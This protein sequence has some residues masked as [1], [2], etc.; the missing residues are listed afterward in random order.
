MYTAYLQY[1][2]ATAV[3][4]RPMLLYMMKMLL[5]TCMRLL[6]NVINIHF[7]A[8]YFTGSQ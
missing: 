5:L 7:S 4:S 2:L 3:K 6:Q 8:E 1:T